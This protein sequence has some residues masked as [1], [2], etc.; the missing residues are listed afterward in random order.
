MVQAMTTALDKLQSEGFHVVKQAISPDVLRPMWNRVMQHCKEVPLG[1]DGYREGYRLT[2]SDYLEL[3]NNAEAL[4]K[5]H[6]FKPVELHGLT[7]VH[8]EPHEGPRWWH[9][10]PA[11]PNEVFVLYYL[12]TVTAENGCLAIRCGRKIKTVP[13]DLGDVLI[14]DPHHEHRSVQNSTGDFRHV[15]RLAIECRRD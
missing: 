7:F 5:E 14:L 8:K 10:D 11:G 1:V 9:T 4:L 3:V 6:G 12:Q 2:D 13:L 15:I